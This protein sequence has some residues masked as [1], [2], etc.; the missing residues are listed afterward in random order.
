MR[1]VRSEGGSA[2]VVDAPAP[3]GEGV[4]V[5][6]SSAGICG[7]DLHMLAFNLPVVMGHEMAGTLDDG[8]PVAVEPIEPCRECAACRSGDYQLCVNGATMILGVG[9]DGGMAEECF[10]PASSIA[11]LPAGLSPSDACLVEPMAVAVH[12]VR[13]GR[14]HP[15]DRVAVVGG[16][17]IGQTSLVAAQAVGASVDMEARHDRQREAA[18]R[19]GAGEVS[20]AYDVVVDA[21]GTTSSLARAVEL[22]RPG[23]RIVMVGNYWDPVEMPSA[24]CFREIDLVPAS[25]YSRVGPSRDFDVATAI[26]AA[27]PAVAD[28]VITHRYPLDAAP[29]AFATA[30]DRAAGAIKV[31]L[32]P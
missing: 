8:T 24:V 16:G 3:I 30:R 9:R 28:A 10:V 25:M 7:S 14:I 19:L 6:V 23:G 4:R 13:R 21:A 29:E 1:A 27:R 18:Q 26:L 2:V 31:V 5:R 32:E 15:A 12:A 20:G 22:C 17:S 11:R